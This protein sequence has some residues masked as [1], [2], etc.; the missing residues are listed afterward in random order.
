MSRDAGVGSASWLRLDTRRA[1]PQRK[2]EQVAECI[3]GAPRLS[4]SW[5]FWLGGTKPNPLMIPP[6]N[7]YWGFTNPD[8]PDHLFINTP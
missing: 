2:E 6:N 3:Q 7:A 8:S 1:F 4:V 5:E